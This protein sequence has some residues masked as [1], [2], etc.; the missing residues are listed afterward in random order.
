MF[1]MKRITLK[2]GGTLITRSKVA[3]EQVKETFKDQIVKIE[4][5]NYSEVNTTMEQ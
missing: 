1:M 5:T 4:D 3:L 2:S